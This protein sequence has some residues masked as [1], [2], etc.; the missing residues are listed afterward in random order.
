M[1]KVDLFKLNQFTEDEKQN[2]LYLLQELLDQIDEGVDKIDSYERVMQ[3]KRSIDRLIET[4]YS[5]ATQEDISVELE[6]MKHIP[7]AIHRVKEKRKKRMVKEIILDQ[8]Q[9]E[10]EKEIKETITTSKDMD[11]TKKQIKSSIKKVLFSVIAH[12][13]DPRKR[14]GESAESNAEHAK[15]YGRKAT[16]G[17]LSTM[18]KAFLTAVSTIV[19]EIAKSHDTSFAKQVEESRNTDR[20]K[21][22]SIPY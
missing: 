12:R 2:Y 21:G 6:T 3:V 4:L 19:H 9:K 16:H 1:N 13:M 10:R 20:Q 14:A 8:Q 22:L 11:E 18:F 15:L 17:L 7:D 5:Q